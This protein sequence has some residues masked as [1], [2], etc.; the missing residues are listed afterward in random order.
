MRIWPVLLLPFL[1]QAQAPRVG[2]IDF[3]GLR[4]VQEQKVRGALGV[5]EGDPL[6]AS[7]SDVEE[8]LE[9]VAGVVRARLEAV[10]CDAG[11]AILY[12]GIEEK[13]APHFDFRTPPTGNDALPKEIVDAYDEFF[14]LVE[15]AIRIGDAG[16]DISHGHSLAYNSQ[17]RRVQERFLILA[18]E[19]EQV[20]RNVLRN[21]A[22]ETQR[23]IAAHLLGYAPVKRRVA[24]DL[25]SAMQDS[26]DSVRNNAM[27]ALIAFAALAGK[28]PE[29]GIR[30]SPTWFIEMLNSIIWTDRNKAAGALARLTESR[31]PNVLAQIR[32]RALPSLIDMA[33]WKSL[34]HALAAFLI[35]GRLAGL[36][37]AEI[38]AAWSK[39]EREEVIVRLNKARP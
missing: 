9:S 29:Q 22:D 14:A 4:E 27:R 21:S 20:L 13:G 25:Q 11:K 18:E 37:E 7:K 3:Y 2:I 16:E 24:D 30:V 26:D 1:A 6:P 10:C 8:R 34:G 12:V 39:G 33:R 15:T 32:E 38:Q 31:D 19:H 35:L 17:V 5:K 28:D 36:P 23:A